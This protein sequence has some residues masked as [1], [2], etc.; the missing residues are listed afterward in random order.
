MS[1]IESVSHESRVF[2]P[3]S[4]FVAQANVD[5]AEFARLNAA[6]AADYP[7]FWAKLAREQL[8]WHK[9]FSRA[10]D[11]SH[12]PF[13]RWFEDGE[14]NASYNCLERNLRRR[15]PPVGGSP[16]SQPPRGKMLEFVPAPIVLFPA[17]GG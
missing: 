4:A 9:P 13:Y 6:A 10:L 7:G 14:L 12:A 17:R 16:A 1:N 5:A 15:S 11:E 8:V 2:A 3:P